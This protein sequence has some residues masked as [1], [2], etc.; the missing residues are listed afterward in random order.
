MATYQEYLTKLDNDGLRIAQQDEPGWNHFYLDE[1]DEKVTTWI[2]DEPLPLTKESEVSAQTNRNK[3]ADLPSLSLDTSEPT[4]TLRCGESVGNDYVGEFYIQ[5]VARI[6]NKVQ[7][8]CVATP[9]WE[10]QPYL[11]KWVKIENIP[12]YILI[13]T[14]EAIQ[15]KKREFDGEVIGWKTVGELIP[16]SAV[17]KYPEGEGCIEVRIRYKNN[18]KEWLEINPIQVVGRKQFGQ[19]DSSI[20][21]NDKLVEPLSLVGGVVGIRWNSK[22]SHQGHYF[23][24]V[25]MH[26]K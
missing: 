22:G 8:R 7:M 13:E 19:P 24:G 11:L 17:N 25:S 15:V 2:T 9:S 4:I 26:D 12:F 1:Q 20:A 18:T 16:I 14:K 3:A 21:F 10:E 23:T 6:K 5:P